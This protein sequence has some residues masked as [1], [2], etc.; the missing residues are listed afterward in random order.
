MERT[1]VNIEV[2]RAPGEK[3]PTASESTSGVALFKYKTDN[4]FLKNHIRVNLNWFG[5][6]SDLLN[7][8]IKPG[9]EIWFLIPK[10]ENITLSVFKDNELIRT[11]VYSSR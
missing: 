4:G 7:D 8:F 11:Q 3:G 1:S 6:S 5:V 9:E 10:G 2:N